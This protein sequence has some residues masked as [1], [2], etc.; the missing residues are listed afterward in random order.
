MEA[1]GG[2]LNQ[3]VAHFAAWLKTLVANLAAGALA[4]AT[5]RWVNPNDR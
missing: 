5:F 2:E 3:V 1:V 4:A